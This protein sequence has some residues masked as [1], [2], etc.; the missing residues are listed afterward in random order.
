MSNAQH[1][2]GG[3]SSRTQ[4]AYPPNSSSG[5]FNHDPNIFF[6]TS[7]EHAVFSQDTSSVRII[8]T[9]ANN[10]VEVFSGDYHVVE[11]EAAAVSP[12]TSETIQEDQKEPE[13]KPKRKRENRYKNAPPGVLTVRSTN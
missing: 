4:P 9:M 1:D 6:D 3:S 2:M 7:N 13:S 8:P 11:Q 12:T 5:P 10:T